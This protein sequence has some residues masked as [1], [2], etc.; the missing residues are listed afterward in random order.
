MPFTKT[1]PVLVFIFVCTVFSVRANDVLDDCCSVPYDKEIL[2]TDLPYN[3]NPESKSQL[4]NLFGR[5][6]QHGACWIDD[7]DELTPKIKLN[8]CRVGTIERRFKITP[9]GYGE[10][11]NCTQ[12]VY[13]K[14]VHDY[15]IRFPEDAESNCGVPN[16]NK[17]EVEEFQCDLLSVSVRDE[18]FVASSDECYK[19][20]RTYRVIN[21]CEFDEEN[22]KAITISRDEDCDGKPGDEPVWVI[23]K[24][25]GDVFIDRDGNHKNKVPS[26]AELDASCGRDDHYQEGYWRS[27]KL[28]PESPIWSRRGFWQYTQVIKVFDG[29]APRVQAGEYDAFC[30]ESNATCTGKVSIPFSVAETCTP[31][32]VSLQVFLYANG[33]AV[34]LV[35]ENDI[36]ADV[37]SGEYPDFELQGA[38]PIG[39]HE[40][41]VMATDGCGNVGSVRIPF[42]VKDCAAPAPICIDMLSTNLMPV[43]DEDRNLTGGMSVVWARDFVVSELP[44]DCTSDVSF[45]IHLK[46]NIDEGTEEPSPDHTNIEITCDHGPVVSVYIYTWDQHGNYSKCVAAIRAT[47]FLSLCDPFADLLIAGQILTPLGEVVD[48]VAVNL[49]GMAENATSTLEKWLLRVQRPGRRQRIHGD[50]K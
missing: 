38:Y 35:P 37:L 20:L 7:W 30:S 41:A 50:P 24:A 49:G 13:V 39:N 6:T 32:E 11:V 21:W 44:E 25:N 47:D 33:E 46:A 4:Q 14:G 19:I 23:K 10:P 3:F 40:F 22:S 31:D 43:Y 45:S 18:R 28:T 9:K 15:K 27:F 16:P 34:D 2:C 12:V 17:I 5:P 26:G 42:E 8:S 1:L 29:N 36:S 48:Q